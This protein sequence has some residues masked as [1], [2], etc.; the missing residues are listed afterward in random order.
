MSSFTEV[1]VLDFSLSRSDDTKPQFLEELKRALL[2]VGFLYI[3]NT[4]IDDKLIEDVIRLGKQ[5]FELPE[6]E[7]LRIEMK[8]C[9]LLY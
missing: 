1:P 3:K 2:E 7:K 8:N 9:E 5:F 6:E 4:G